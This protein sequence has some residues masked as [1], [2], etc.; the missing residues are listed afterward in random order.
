MYST[1]QAQIFTLH[2]VQATSLHHVDKSN[3]FYWQWGDLIAFCC[4][5]FF[6]GEG[7]RGGCNLKTAPV[8]KKKNNK[9][10]KT[11]I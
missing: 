2:D 1:S 9:A 7:G 6:H 10:Q 8:I 11:V 5:S 4:F 3:V